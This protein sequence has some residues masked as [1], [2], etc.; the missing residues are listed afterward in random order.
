ME[1]YCLFYRNVFWQFYHLLK[2]SCAD[3]KHVTFWDDDLTRGVLLALFHSLAHSE[4]FG[5]KKCTRKCSL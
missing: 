1:G 2:M 5:K 4:G 3:L